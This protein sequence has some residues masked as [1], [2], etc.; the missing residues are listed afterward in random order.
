MKMRCSSSSA[1]APRGASGTSIASGPRTCIA[2][3]RANGAAA[4]PSVRQELADSYV[5]VQIMK[6]NGMRMLTAL[7]RR[8]VLGP[9]AS[10]GKLYWSTWH[11]RLGERAMRVLGADALVVEGDGHDYHLD[12]AHRIF[13][14]SRSE[15]IYAGSSEIQH[16]IIGERVLGLPREPR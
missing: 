14:S 11:R 8:G 16:N 6:F 7:V 3:A 12:E 15:T 1:Y 2:R 10:I 5:G 4:D 13:M 9:A